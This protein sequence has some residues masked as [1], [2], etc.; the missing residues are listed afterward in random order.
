MPVV[1]VEG[2]HGTDVKNVDAILNM[3]FTA[4]TRTDHW[5]GQGIYFYSDYHL[6]LWWIK[7]KLKS[8]YGHSCAV[9][10]AKM[11]CE[12]GTFLDMDSV[13]GLDYFL[14]E[15][16][17]ILASEAKELSIKFTQDTVRNLCFALDLL[18][19]F[20]G[21]KLIAMTFHKDNPSY[22]AENVEAF[23]KS[24]FPLPE[25]ITYRERQICASSN[26]IIRSKTCVFPMKRTK[27]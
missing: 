26:D 14:R 15:I 7:K 2:F 21:I 22:A 25:S 24:H 18:K 4:T 23:K 1:T 6:A 10:Q 13:F 3:E 12:E 8:T 19:T 27:W 17:S 11:E 5:L 20:R 16:D 9:I